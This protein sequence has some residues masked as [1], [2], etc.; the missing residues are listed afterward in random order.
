MDGRRDTTAVVTD[1][2]GALP[3]LRTLYSVARRYVD[4]MDV[5]SSL[6]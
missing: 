3:A 4:Q 6:C 1:A 2:T 5:S